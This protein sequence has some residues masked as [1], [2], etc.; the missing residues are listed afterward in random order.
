MDAIGCPLDCLEAIARVRVP[1][2]FLV[3]WSPR[4]STTGDRTR[5]I[6]LLHPACTDRSRRRRGGGGQAK[7]TVIVLGASLRPSWNTT[8]VT[9]DRSPNRSEYGAGSSDNEP[10]W[11]ESESFTDRPSATTTVSGAVARAVHVGPIRSLPVAASPDVLPI[12][13]S[14]I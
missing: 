9:L 5:P 12:S 13:R 6:A 4:K 1:F 7:R 8:A 11:K 14:S 2:S 3:V 10:P